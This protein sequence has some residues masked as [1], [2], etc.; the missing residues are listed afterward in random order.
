MPQFKALADDYTVVLKSG[1]TL[2][3]KQVAGGP[4]LSATVLAADG[5]VLNVMAD[6]T[7]NPLCHNAPAMH[8]DNT[9][10]S[11]S[12]ALLFRYGSFTFFVGGDLTRDVEARLVCPSNLVGRVTLYQT[13]QHGLDLSNTRCSFTPWSPA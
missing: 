4:P 5:K 8:P 12:V 13:D 7:P 1:D 11:K 9:Q 2:S 3:I 6:P 10:N